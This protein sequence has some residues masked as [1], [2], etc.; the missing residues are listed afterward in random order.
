MT[1]V[2]R[3][4]F[5]LSAKDLELIEMIRERC[6]YVTDSEAL[7]AIIRYFAEHALCM[8]RQS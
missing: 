3:R 7:R 5:S 4:N 1:R 6:G 8:K 2:V